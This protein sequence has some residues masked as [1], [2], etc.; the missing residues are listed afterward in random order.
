MWKWYSVYMKNNNSVV[1]VLVAIVFL[2]GGYFLGVNKNSGNTLSVSTTTGDTS[3]VLVATTSDTATNKVVVKKVVPVTTNNYL[4]VDQRTVLNGVYITPIKV[5]YDSRCPKDV[6]CIQAGTV[7]VGVLLESGNLSQNIIITIGK[8]I[9]FAGK[10]VTL[11]NV[12]PNKVST[13]TILESDYRF[14]FTVK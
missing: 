11:T 9:I 5:A 3:S 8:S 4:K 10:T 1:L 13:K 14:T 6:Q 7:D 2:V 12:A